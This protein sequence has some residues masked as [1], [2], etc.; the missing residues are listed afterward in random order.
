MNPWKTRFPLLTLPLIAEKIRQFA[1]LLLVCLLPLPAL[2]WN[3]GG[4]RLVAHL[5][6]QQLAPETRAEVA[7]LLRAHPERERWLKRAKE[8]DPD[9]ALF[10]E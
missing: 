3:A 6:W 8:A 4:H 1:A 7:R 10:V 5:A 9:L 2:A